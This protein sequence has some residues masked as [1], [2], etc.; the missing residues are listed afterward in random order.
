MDIAALLTSAG[1]NIAVCVVLFSFYSVLRKQ[2]GNVSVYFGRRLA[3]KHSRRL[4][5]CLERFVPSPSW[6]LKAWDTSEDEIL[7][8]GGLDAVVFVRILVFSIRVFSIAAVICISIVLPVNYNGKTRMHKDIPWESLEVFT[9]ENVNG[10]KWLWAHCLAL[11]IITLAACTLL[12]FEYK[13]I[14]NLRLLHIIGSPPNPSHFSILVRSIPWSSEESYCETVKKFF[15]Y[16]HASTYLSHQM[17]YK[18]GTVQKLK[19]DAGH[20]CKVLRDSSL[21]K[22]CRPSFMQCWCSGAPK[23]SF[24]MIPDEID[25]IPGYTDMHL[26]TRK[27]ECAAAFVFF[28]SRYAA[29]MAAHSLQTSNPM[30]WATDIAPEPHD[31]YW[32]NISIPYRQLWIRNIATLVASIAFMLVFLIP[33]TFVQGLTQLDELQKM[34]PFLIGILKKK[35]IRQLVTGYLPSVI[36]VLF[37]CAV[38]PMMM[39]FSAVEGSISRSERKKSACCKV[40]Y[41]TIWNVFFVNVFTGSVISQLSVF[42]SV[43]D[44]PAQLAKAVPS[45]ATFFTTYVLSSGWASLGVEVMQIFPLICNLLQRYVLRQKDDA[46][47]GSLSFPYHTEVPRVLLFGFLGFTCAILAPLILPFL[48]IYFFIAY[49]IYRNQILNVYITKYDSGGQF[50]PIAHNTT[51]FSLLVAQLIALGVFGLKRSSVASGF[52]IPL[53]IG[54]LLFHQYCR[55]R[56]LPVFRS[57]SAQFVL[58]PY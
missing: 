10:A 48:L 53:L 40:L 41:F 44:L 6:I 2:P 17:I 52:T 54:T 27:K 45:Q 20:M 55:Q 46:S 47:G 12:Y 5:F 8:I 34:F 31:V 57:N 4:E 24:K 28:K 22:S 35:F 39:L 18:S 14:T 11:Y 43:T 38:P 51:V 7:A 50:W 49:L 13:S 30:L 37:M 25:S 16:Y 32:S 33:V 9:I 3:S 15:S 56:F 42:S 26:D 23:N 58:D 1:I 19:D 21:E 36:L 29:H